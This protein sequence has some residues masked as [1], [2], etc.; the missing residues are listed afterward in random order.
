MARR[1]PTTLPPPPPR[2]TVVHAWDGSDYGAEYLN[3]VVGQTLLGTA[4][5]VE[6][7]GWV[8]VWQPRME[9]QGWFPPAFA[10]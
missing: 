6:E 7:D 9:R 4:P 8:K 2:F 10:T 1:L 5:L 3:L